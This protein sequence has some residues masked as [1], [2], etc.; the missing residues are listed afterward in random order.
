MSERL[1]SRFRSVALLASCGVGLHC[2]A[3]PEETPRETGV[4]QGALAPVVLHPLVNTALCLEAGPASS[5][6]GLQATIAQCTGGTSQAWTYTNGTL[7][8]G[9]RCLDVNAGADANGT[10]VQLWD[11]QAGNLNQQWT[12]QGNRWVWTG[13]DKCLHVEGS[14]GSAGTVVQLWT[15]DLQ[16]G[17]GWI[18]GGTGLCQ[19]RPTPTSPAD[20]GAGMPAKDPALANQSHRFFK[21]NVLDAAT[22]TPIAGARLETVGKVVLQSDNNGVVAFYEPG[23]MGQEVWFHVSRPGYEAAADFFGN[24]G[25]ALTAVEGGAGEITL[26]KVG[27]P[28]AM[29]VGDQQTRLA[30]S[31]VPTGSNRCMTIRLFD[32]QNQRGVPLAAFTTAWGQYFSDSQGL[33]AYCDEDHLGWVDFTVTSHGYTY[34]TGKGSVY[35][36][37]GQTLELGLDR[38]NIAER[39]YRTTGGGI[40]RDSLQLGYKTPLLQ[41][42]LNGKVIGQD[43]V[44][45]TVYKG[46]IFWTWGDTDRPAYPLG[47]F[48][49]SAALS[50]LPSSGGLHPN[51]G[52]NQTYYTDSTGFSR[53]IVEDFTPGGPTWVGALVPVPDASGQERLFASYSKVDGNMAALQRGLLRFNDSSQLFERVITDYPLQGTNVPSGGQASRYLFPDREYV[54]FGGSLRAPATAES[55]LDK[56]SYQVFTAGKTDGSGQLEKASD[57]TLVYG[58]KKGGGVDRTTAQAVQAAG[59]DK[60]QS[61]EGHTRDA[62][63]GAGLS[64]TGQSI[65]WNES[66]GRFVQIAQQFG[67]GTSV[68][69]EIWYAEGDTPMGPWV[70]ARKIITHDQYTF[71]NTYVHPYLSPDGGRTMYL[72]GTHTS[73]FDAPPVITPRYNYNQIM[74]RLNVDD[75]RLALPVP[76]Y[77]LTASL[78]G[79]FVTKKGVA[80]GTSPLAAAFLAPERQ[81]PGTVPVGWS[82]PSCATPRRLTV[83]G[84]P[85]DV[86][87][88]ALPP[89]T[90]P[91]PPKTV[92]LYEYSHADGRRAYS[93]NASLALSGFTRS[94]TPIAH[95]WENPLRVK[96]PVADFLGNVVANAGADQCLTESTQGGG[97]RVTLN[98]SASRNLTG[99]S[100]TFTWLL[101]SGATS[102]S[103]TSCPSVS[104]QVLNVRLPAG[105]HTV[106]L[107][108]RDGSGNTSS[109]TLVVQVKAL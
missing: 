3:P 34:P 15:C 90:S 33:I 1:V 41:P 70:D 78:P 19:T 7:R 104:G 108:A 83:G 42:V 18:D 44:I 50:D 58:W 88:Y 84:T 51:L 10:K 40:Y 75:T 107:Q 64:L 29:N 61:L 39:L 95:V 11:C 25:K 27:T 24:R 35:A 9:N 38:V 97:A 103:G 53:G 55:L 45:S 93:L 54:L 37:W 74:Y 26:N 68:L 62:A 100:T 91:L 52:L 63:T 16:S 47:N 76:V 99:Q 105:L 102:E 17:Q 109:D 92:P 12:R 67:G 13:H 31:A 82:G 20:P 48:R 59:L 106:T 77:E 73:S 79:N 81:A 89:G 36:T 94:T 87:F 69:G 96:L 65:T 21:I 71:Y 72:E 56:T 30:A 98:A 8:A 46:K 101:P 14:K 49:T 23:L 43:S 66:R 85:A 60:G 32:K 28:P 22:R 4:I 5:F 80:P 57:G 6:N 2:S 86:L